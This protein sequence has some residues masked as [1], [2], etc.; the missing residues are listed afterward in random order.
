MKNIKNKLIKLI[1]A[2]HTLMKP[3]KTNAKV[4]FRFGEAHKSILLPTIKML[5]F[6]GTQA[7]LLAHQGGHSEGHREQK[8][9]RKP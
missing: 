4:L 9:S 6:Y 1:K 8:L 7:N 3:F 2:N 5:K